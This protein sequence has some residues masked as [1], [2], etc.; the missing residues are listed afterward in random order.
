MTYGETLHVRPTSTNTSCPMFS[1][2]TISEYAQ[3]PGNFNESNLTLLFLPGNHTVNVNVIITNILQLEILGNTSVVAP[4]RVVCSSKVGFTFR[5][6]PKLRI[7]GLSFFSCA[8]S[9]VVQFSEYYVDF[10]T[11]YGLHLQSVQTAEIIDCTFQDSYG[12]ALGV[13]DSHVV[14]KGNNSFLNNCKP[15]SNYNTCYGGGVFASRSNLSFT[16]SNS[17]FN[18]SAESGGG[19][20]AETNSNVNICGNITFIG[21]GAGDEGGGLSAGT[22]SNVNIIANTTFIGNSAN[23]GGGVSAGLNS[24]VNIGG[25]TTFTDN[26][27]KTAGGGVSTGYNSNLHISGNTTFIGNSANIGGG[28]VYAELDSNMVTISGMTSF[29]SNSASEDGGGVYAQPNDLTISGSTNFINNSASG[30][31]GGGV[32]AG[33]DGSMNISWNTTFI[34]NS[35]SN[36]GGGLLT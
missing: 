2:H 7:D 6:I 35:A 12:S 30:G 1:C 4:T 22:D 3:D 15:N 11:Y 36:G 10:T 34:A 32:Y 19:I 28:G 16:G 20:H 14:L 8:R 24:N 18:N 17:F 26:S 9:R 27:A 29:I 25:S 23:Y 31:G 21:N 5:D 33:S 13:V